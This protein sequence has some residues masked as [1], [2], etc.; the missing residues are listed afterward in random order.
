M[1]VVGPG[2]GM[3]RPAAIIC[4]AQDVAQGESLLRRDFALKWM[5]VVPRPGLGL[6][7]QG[8]DYIRVSLAVVC[9]AKANLAIVEGPWVP[10]IMII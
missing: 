5:R 10:Q 8:Y 7:G 1:A 3:R 9:G 2:R 4:V 6:E